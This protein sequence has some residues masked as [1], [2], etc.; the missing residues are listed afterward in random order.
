[1]KT[2][3]WGWLTAGVLAAGLNAGYHDGGLRWAHEAVNRLQHGSAAVV[4]L[5]TGRTD[6]FLTEARLV[7]ARSETAGCRLS[8]A[9]A[10]VQTR[11]AHAETRIARSE[12]RVDRFET[13]ADMDLDMDMAQLDQL[14]ANR[15]RIQALVN[16]REQR[17]LAHARIP[18]AAFNPVVF[19]SVHVSSD[20]P[21]VRVNIPRIPMMKMPAVPEVH[22][23]TASAGPV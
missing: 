21:R 12:A 18:G 3:A 17:Q 19:K 16:A 5:A 4:A 9:I 2:Q 1:M 20:C 11:I 23:E 10:R 7:S 15:E 6:Q 8:T 14:D 13:M 22:V